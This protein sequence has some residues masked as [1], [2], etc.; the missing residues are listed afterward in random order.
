MESSLLVLAREFKKLRDDTRRI[1]DM[2]VGPQGETGQQGERGPIG[3]MGIQG[4]RGPMGPTGPIGP[5]GPGG[6]PGKDGK[7]GQDGAKGQDGISVVDAEIAIDGHLVF[8]LS[9]G[10]VLDVGELDVNS[11]LE[12]Y[13][14]TQTVDSGGSGTSASVGSSSV[15]FGGK[16]TDTTVS[17]SLPTITSD[18]RVQVWIDPIA[19]VNNTVDNHWVD[20]L[21]V[22]AYITAGVGFTIR[23]KCRTGF[24]HGVYTVGYVI[25]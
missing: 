14:S 1:L 22:H 25:N 5:T 23:A 4:E 17:V 19:T 15:N 6:L 18:N 3:P 13:F 21:D 11:K 10:R 16:S 12:Q 24:A 2:P 8:T 9:D 7:D 20:D